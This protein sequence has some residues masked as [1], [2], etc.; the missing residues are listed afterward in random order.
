MLCQTLAEHGK[1]GGLKVL[2]GVTVAAARS[3][4]PKA[5]ATKT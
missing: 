1:N 2:E 3:V 4:L 5:S